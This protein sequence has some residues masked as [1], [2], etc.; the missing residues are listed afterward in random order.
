M[1]N[2]EMQFVHANNAPST[3]EDLYD[4]RMILNEVYRA[5]ASKFASP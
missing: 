4:A 3:I 2:F 1:I 5:H